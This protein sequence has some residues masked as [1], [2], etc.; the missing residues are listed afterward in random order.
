MLF[1]REYI[2]LDSVICV[3]NSIITNNFQETE[4]EQVIEKCLLN[5]QISN[6]MINILSAGYFTPNFVYF[7]NSNRFLHL[8]LLKFTIDLQFQIQLLIIFSHSQCESWNCYCV[9]KIIKLFKVS[10]FSNTFITKDILLSLNCVKGKISFRV[11]FG[12]NFLS[13]YFIWVQLSIIRA[14]L[15]LARSIGSL[16]I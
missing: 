12:K 14:I 10:H 4:R 13:K 3:R 16:L 8:H 7:Y 6:S 11:V 15:I 9:L 5:N 1:A 2:L